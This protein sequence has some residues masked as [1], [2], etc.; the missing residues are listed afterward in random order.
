MRTLTVAQLADFMQTTEESVLQKIHGGEIVA[1]NINTK[2]NAQR[3]RWRILE[4]DFASFLMRTRF[5]SPVQTEKPKRAKRTS[6][7]DFFP[8]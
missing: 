5:Q 6:G 3:P 2:P 8:A 1:S 4:S 7:K